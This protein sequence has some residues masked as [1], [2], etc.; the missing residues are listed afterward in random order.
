L[1]KG[2]ILQEGRPVLSEELRR[3]LDTVRYLGTDIDS[4]VFNAYG[5]ERFVAMHRA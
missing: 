5:S 2:F 4:V 3:M 1:L